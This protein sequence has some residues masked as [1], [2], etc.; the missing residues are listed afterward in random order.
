MMLPS[1]PDTPMQVFVVIGIALVIAAVVYPTASYEAYEDLQAERIKEESLLQI[2]K[3]YLDLATDQRARMKE[4]ATKGVEVE[5]LRQQ[6]E[7]LYKRWQ[8]QSNAGLGFGMGGVILVMV[9]MWLWW[10]KKSKTS[11]QGVPGAVTP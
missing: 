6:E 1:L 5:W 2:E 9:G 8:K 10:P 7:N 4:I 3:D 11:E